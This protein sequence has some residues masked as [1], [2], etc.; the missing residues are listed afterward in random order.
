MY[1]NAGN[2]IVPVMNVGGYGNNNGMWGGDGGWWA[3]IL[4]ALLFGWGGNGFGFGNGNGG[5]TQF[6]EAAVQ[7][8]FDNQTVINKLDGISNGLCSLG[9]D[10]LA[11]MN[12]IQNTV[13]QTGWGI[14]QSVNDGTVSAMRNT[15]E[16]S[17]QF[18]D[19]CCE[20][21][22]A[23]VQN[24]ADAA[25]NTCAI[26][27]A[28]HQAADAQMQNCNAN[29]RQLHDELVAMRMEDKNETIAQLR[30]QLNDCSRDSAL[31][32]N[33]QY[34]INQVNPRS[35]PAY[36]TCNP[37]TGYVFPPAANW[38]RQNNNC[39]GNNYS[40]CGNYNG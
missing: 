3:W 20:N 5:S 4:F 24:R 26:T 15:W 11:Q 30:Q 18:A 35:E 36:L 8:G 31:A 29:Y 27:T 19:C 10:Q 2:G 40:C 23:T 14:Q 32:A 1:N 33:A 7:R 25:A 39:C 6:V 16:L 28:I 38:P 17:R 37:N 22:V 12:G 9:Y 21:R 34:I 13:M